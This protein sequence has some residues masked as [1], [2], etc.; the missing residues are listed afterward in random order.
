[1]KLKQLLEQMPVVRWNADP[2]LEIADLT[3]DSRQVKPG[4]LFFAVPG[5]QAD[6][7]DFLPQAVSAGAAAAIVQRPVEGIPYVQVES[8]YQAM[9]ALADRFWDHPS[10]KLTVIGVTGTNGKTTT[11]Y[12]VKELLEQLLGASVGL[13]GTNQNMVAHEII[14]TRNTTPDGLALQRLFH[15]MVQAGCTHCVMEVSSHALAEGRVD[16]V[17]FDIGLFTNLTQDHLDYHKTMENYRRAKAA[18]FRACRAGA[19]NGDDPATPAILAEATSQNMTYG[20]RGRDLTLQAREIRLDRD[21]VSF[22]A[23]YQGQQVPVTLQIPGS[24]SVYN[25]LTALSAGLL[26]GLPLPA[27]AQAMSHARGIKGRMEVVPTPLDATVVIDYAHTPDALENVLTALGDAGKGGRLVTL[28]G[29]GGDRDRGK[30]PKMGRIAGTLS[31]L[32]I[33]TS[34]NPRTE[35]PKAII[36]EILPGLAGCGAE[37][38]VEPDRRAA[39]RWGLNQ[40]KPGDT[41]LLAGKGQETYQEI[42]HVRHHLDEREEIAGYFGGK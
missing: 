10:G 40:L 39:I 14:P 1:M 21:G 41:L 3:A 27:L 11:T 15:R 9:G 5:H 38:H 28:F 17:D 35:D 24:F 23:C 33:V 20:V 2:E 37:I 4:T 34:D 13:I 7:H 25:A 12:L 32:V 31:D 42:C 26:L 16:Q 29:C 18:L 19:L 6:G 8:S 22:I 30:R 36:D